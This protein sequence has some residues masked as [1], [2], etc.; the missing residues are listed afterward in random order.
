[1]NIRQKHGIEAL[2]KAIHE[3]ENK[4]KGISGDIDK[5]NEKLQVLMKAVN[6]PVPDRVIDD[7]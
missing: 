2:S 3:T 4:R 1:M 6:N 7:E 5:I